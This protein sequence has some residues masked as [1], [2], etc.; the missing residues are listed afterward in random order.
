MF[1]TQLNVRLA[2]AYHVALRTVQDR[3]GIPISE[4]VRRAL[5]LW[6]KHQGVTIEGTDESHARSRGGRRRRRA[7]R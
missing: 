6:A 7:R 5:L 4:Q 2:D 3:D 1:T